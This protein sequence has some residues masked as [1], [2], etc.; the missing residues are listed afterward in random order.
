MAQLR[1]IGAFIDNSVLD[2]CWKESE[3]Y[4]ST[5]V[6]QIIKGNHVKRRETAHRHCYYPTGTVPIITGSVLSVSPQFAPLS[7]AVGKAACWCLF[8]RQRWNKRSTRKTSWNHGSSGNRGEKIE[9]FDAQK[10]NFPSFKVMRHFTRMVMAMMQF[11]RAVR[12]GNWALHFP[13]LEILTKYFFA[14][15]MI[16][17]ARMVSVYLAEM[18]MLNESDS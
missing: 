10:E 14:Y 8:R 16:N 13:A 15:D 1:E 12:T 4:G 6:E 3:L 2:I 9:A 5:T 17:C 18:Q 11:I 7:W